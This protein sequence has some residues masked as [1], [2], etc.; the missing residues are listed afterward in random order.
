M[1]RI[2]RFTLQPR[3]TSGNSRL[4][5][6]GQVTSVHVPGTAILDQ[7]ETS[8]GYLLVTDQDCPFEETFHF[9]LLDRNLHVRSRRNLG[10]GFSFV[11]GSQVRTL[12]ELVWEDDRHFV[13]ILTGPTER[14]RFTIRQPGIPFIHPRLTATRV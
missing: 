2:Q 8:A 10:A 13:A 12:E 7:F 9:I 6:D 1:R 5:A 14:W 4:I 11:P 3:S